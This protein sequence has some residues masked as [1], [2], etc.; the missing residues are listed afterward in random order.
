MLAICRLSVAF[1]EKSEVNVMRVWCEE[2]EVQKRCT[3]LGPAYSRCTA[4]KFGEVATCMTA[5]IKLP[6][7]PLRL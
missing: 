2:T 4:D 1:N 5:I 6:Q 3:E 7:L